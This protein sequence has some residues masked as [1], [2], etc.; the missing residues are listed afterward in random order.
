MGLF[1]QAQINKMA[2][3]GPIQAVQVFGRKKT[4]TAVAHC[5]RGNGLIKVNGRP[6]KHIEPATLQYKLQEPILLLG[7]NRFK[8]LIS[9]YVSTVEDILLK[10]MPSDRP[11][12]NLWSPIIKNTLMKPP[13]RKSRASWPIMTEVYW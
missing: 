6:L 1:P 10:F 2:P 3:K 13:R 4:A 11:S 7:K 9:E 12:P 5:K 8:G